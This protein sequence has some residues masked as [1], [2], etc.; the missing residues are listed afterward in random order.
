MKNLRKVNKD[1]YQIDIKLDK[2]DFPVDVVAIFRTKHNEWS[3]CDGQPE[4]ARRVSDYNRY[5][6]IKLAS[7]KLFAKDLALA[8]ENETLYPRFSD[9]KY[10]L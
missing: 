5:V 10:S 2:W 6:F 9:D 7:A 1:W 4:L 8:I 3:V